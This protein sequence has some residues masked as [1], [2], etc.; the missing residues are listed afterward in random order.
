VR[1][2]LCSTVDGLQGLARITLNGDTHPNLEFTLKDLAE[3][4]YSIDLSLRRG[5]LAPTLDLSAL[6][7]EPTVRGQFV[8]DILEEQMEPEKRNR[9][10]QM[11]LRA[12]EGKQDLEA[13]S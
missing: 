11:G 9:I 8:R 3:A 5:K 1:D 4:G 7:K 2:R 13:F 12:L 10:L 6:S